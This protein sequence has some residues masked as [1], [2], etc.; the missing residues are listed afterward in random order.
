VLAA[1]R[2]AGSHVLPRTYRERRLEGEGARLWPTVGAQPVAKE[3]EL[4]VHE[5]PQR[6]VRKAQLQLRFCPVTLRPPNKGVHDPALRLITVTAIEVREIDAPEHA[7]PIL[8]RLLTGL[9][10]AGV[11]DAMQCVRCHELR[12]LIERFHFALKGG[13]HIEESQLRTLAGLNRLLA[14]LSAVAVRLLWMTYSA[15]IR[16]RHARWLPPLPS[17]GCSTA[18]TTPRRCQTGRPRWARRRCGW[19][20]SAASWAARAMVNPVSRCSGA[21]SCDFT[22]WSPATSS[23]TQMCAMH[24]RQG[25]RQRMRNVLPAMNRVPPKALPSGSV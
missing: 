25:G 9:P 5:G 19:P 24:S 1:P 11:A 13:C 12:W 22:T 21:A 15:R 14:L 23:P 17:G 4:L 6:T 2:R 3:F 10:V 8:W 20:N 18:T 16:T 7:T